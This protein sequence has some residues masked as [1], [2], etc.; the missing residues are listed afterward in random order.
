MRDGDTSGLSAIITTLVMDAA[1]S[2]IADQTAVECRDRPHLRTPPTTDA[3][4]IEK[5]LG[6][7]I[8]AE[9]ST[10]GPPPVLPL[11]TTVP[12]LVLAGQFDPVA[13]VAL[14]RQIADEIGAHALWTEFP[15]V[16]HNVRFFSP[17]AA[18]IVAQFIEH[19]DA[20]LDTS[21]RLARPPIPFLPRSKRP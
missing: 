14:S 5:V 4:P 12:T 6:F 17:C 2:D 3:A 20:A 15:G 16:G 9:W 8:C 10:L 18:G 21:C 11:G 1:A 13:G 19:P 7:G